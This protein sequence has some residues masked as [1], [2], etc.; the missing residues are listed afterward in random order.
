MPTKTDKLVMEFMQ[1]KQPADDDMH[2]A[3]RKLMTKPPALASLTQFLFN[4]NKEARAAASHYEEENEQLKKE[5]AA[6]REPPLVP[7]EVL[8]VLADGR[9]DIL[10]GN[11]RLIVQ[12]VPE[13]DLS[14][15]EPGDEVFLNGDGTTV[16]CKNDSPAQGGFVATVSSTT[17]I[18]GLVVLRT[19]GEE[20]VV[21]LCP[22]S[23][24]TELEPG[25]RVLVRRESNCVTAKLGGDQK[26]SYELEQPPAVTF[27][28]IGGLDHVIREVS[29]VLD[30]AVHHRDVATELGLEAGYG[31]VLA[32]APGIGKSMLAKAVANHLAGYGEPTSFLN[33][34]PG[35]LRSM[36]YG[37]TEAKIRELFAFARKAP[38]V[39]VIFLDEVEN[40]GV[41]GDGQSID[42]RVLAALL[43][44]IDG[45]D[46]VDNLFVIA[47]T[48]RIDLCDS[49]LIRHG[50]L[51]DSVFTLPR[52]DAH[53]TR[54][55]LSK[56]LSAS[57]PYG[58]DG[59]GVDDEVHGR[60]ALL[61]AGISYLF[62]DRGHG[63]LAT[64]VL[65]TS[66]PREIWPA[67]V[68][69]GALVAG[70]VKKAKQRV[71][72]RRVRSDGSLGLQVEDILTALDDALLGE[73][74]K[75]R[76]PV[77]ARR[78][79]DFA[80]ADQIARIELPEGRRSPRHRY[81]RAA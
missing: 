16:V 67:D 41:R 46:P 14:S 62:A 45:L 79:L 9:L 13:F 2:E 58:P 18:D 24:R 76:T 66:E 8:Q 56:H 1:G 25:D 73:V 3:I 32:G 31:L 27:D 22:A 26:S 4:R 74:D 52:P 10:G 42:G 75:L 50:R 78:N 54:E 77:A 48:N 39:V 6:V 72:M 15:I 63:L 55:I 70:A 36:Y 53:A 69:S 64:A 17:A 7:A 23:L 12:A 71:A 60:E 68:M 19:V 29:D 65:T 34:K 49:A 44:E 21:G 43:A 5:I 28:D 30:L 40:F 37:Q 11:R 57:L 38:G 81:L 59:T 33:V 80:D 20:E 51:G 61:D 35:E 47:A